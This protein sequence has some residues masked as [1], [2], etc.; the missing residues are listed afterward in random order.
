VNLPYLVRLICICLA[1]FFLVNIAA[2]LAVARFSRA[3]GCLARRMPSRDGAHFLLVMRLVPAVLAAGVVICFC[4]PSYLWMEPEAIDEQVGW[5]CL[6]AAAITVLGW[7][8]PLYRTARA[9]S[10][11]RRFLHRCLSSSGTP[12][13][14]NPAVLIAPRDPLFALAGIL[15]PRVLVS[16]CAITSFP[17]E[18]LTTVLRHEH[19]HRESFDNLKRFLILLTPD[20]LP[21]VRAMGPLEHDWAQMTEWAADDRATGGDPLRAVALASALVRAARMASSSPP[22][23]ELITALL[24]DTR[25]LPVRVERLLGSSLPAASRTQDFPIYAA[26]AAV[27]MAIMAAGAIQPAA[28]SFA[29]GIIEH[30]VR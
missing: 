1:T 22:P 25:D 2:C 20:I 13:G 30:L 5:L 9:V 6:M 10:R 7:V 28:L 14:A 12:D 26:G 15:Q 4:I 24:T 18:E 19:A 29:H 17:E 23:P 11:S 16:R 27:C 21:F 3:L 8:A